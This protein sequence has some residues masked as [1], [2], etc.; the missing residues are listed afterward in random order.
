MP[1]VLF[2]NFQCSKV[3]VVLFQHASHHVEPIRPPFVLFEPE[4]TSELS[5]RSFANG[6]LV[7][8]K[9]DLKVGEVVS[10]QF[11]ERTR[12]V[13]RKHH[14]H[15]QQSEDVCVLSFLF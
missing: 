8:T 2:V 15:H 3:F 6:T 14:S 1:F 12:L 13:R 4:F 11:N 5:L 10:K 7:K 9:V